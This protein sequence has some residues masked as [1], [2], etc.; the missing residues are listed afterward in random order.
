MGFNSSSIWRKT[1]LAE[2]HGELE[3]LSKNKNDEKNIKEKVQSD[4]EDSGAEEDEMKVDN[5]QVNIS[6]KTLFLSNRKKRWNKLI[7]MKI[8][9]WKE[10]LARVKI[11][12]QIMR[13]EQ[14]VTLYKV[15]RF[16]QT[17]TVVFFLIVIDFLRMDFDLRI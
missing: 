11:E 5:N 7:Q 15:N 6:N 12:E 3:K 14:I 16:L 4:N 1:K 9:L 10:M 2:L 13:V 8:N 17:K